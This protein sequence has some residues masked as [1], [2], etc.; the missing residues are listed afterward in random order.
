[1]AGKVRW[2]R[3]GDGRDAAVC[4]AGRRGWCPVVFLHPYADSHRFFELA[5]PYLP[6][7]IHAYV[8]TQ[9]GHGDADK[10]PSGYTLEEFSADVAAFLDA[11]GVDR[12][13]VVGHSSGGCR[14]ALRARG[15]VPAVASPADA[16]TRSPPEPRSTRDSPYPGTADWGAVCTWWARTV[17]S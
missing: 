16:E 7:H 4:R 1:V 13:V 3:L 8:P 9:R 10:P 15:C 14:P 2:V 6:A 5:L 17:R 11:T 12:A